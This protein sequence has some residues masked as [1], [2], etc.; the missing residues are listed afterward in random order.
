MA[1]HERYQRNP[2][3]STTL[4]EVL[5][6]SR[7]G[8]RITARLLDAAGNVLEQR[9]ATPGEEARLRREERGS[10]KEQFAA[11]VSVEAKLNIIAGELGLL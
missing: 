3:G 6:V 7:V 9:P 10:P 1:R 8:G 11:A 5:E 4:I 2:D